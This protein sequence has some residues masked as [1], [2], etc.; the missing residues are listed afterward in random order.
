[1]TSLLH[2]GILP[3]PRRRHN[4]AVKYILHPVG[5]LDTEGVRG[6]ERGFCV[7]LVVYYRG[8]LRVVPRPRAPAQVP[9]S[10]RLVPAAGGLPSPGLVPVA[11]LASPRPRVVV[12]L[13]C[14]EHFGEMVF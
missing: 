10:L 14:G 5:N 7:D 12:T 3:P 4:R 2:A 9:P 1:M 13:S 8:M 11:V 6:W